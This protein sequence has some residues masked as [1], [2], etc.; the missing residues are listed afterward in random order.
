MCNPEMRTDP[1]AVAGLLSACWQRIRI[2]W[3]G[4]VLRGFFITVGFTY[5]FFFLDIIQQ[6]LVFLNVLLYIVLEMTK[7]RF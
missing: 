7:L 5:R 1:A 2:A 3:F 6:G 4:C